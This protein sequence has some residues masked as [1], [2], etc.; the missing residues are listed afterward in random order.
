VT[1]AVF[2]CA[3]LLQAA[4]RRTGPAAECLQAVRDGRLKLFVSSNL[5]LMGDDT[6]RR[7]FPKLTVVDPVA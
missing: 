2:D 3:I 5:D 1:R 4:A 7:Q 6:F